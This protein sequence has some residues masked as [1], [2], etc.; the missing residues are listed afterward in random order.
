MIDRDTAA[1]LSV[2]QTKRDLAD[3]DVQFTDTAADLEEIE[4]EARA[5]IEV[6]EQIARSNHD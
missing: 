1:T 2:I 4:Q 3:Y 6:L 5:L